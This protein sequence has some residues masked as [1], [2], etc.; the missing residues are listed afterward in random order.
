MTCETDREHSIP[1]SGNGKRE[2]LID[3]ENI[4]SAMCQVT[5]N[6]FSRITI[7][8]AQVEGNTKRQ[9]HVPCEDVVFKGITKEFLL[10]GLADGQSGTQYGAAGGQACLEAIFGLISSVGIETLIHSPFPD[11]LPCLFVQT[12]RKVL[13]PMANSK[14]TDLKEFAST[15]LIIAV[16]LKSG[17][18]IL[19]H[20]GDGYAI[21]IPNTG[22]PAL[23]SKPDTGLTSR[24]TWLTTS[25]NAIPHFYVTFG[26]IENKK[27]ILLVS[28]GAVCFC[29]GQHIPWR[30]KDL[31]TDGSQLQLHEYLM[32]SEPLD[33]ATYIVLDFHST[34]HHSLC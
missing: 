1:F 25:D 12:I 5:G 22:D 2:P 15:L 31:L 6:D 7:S 33:D 3:P 16:S 19:L 32:Q 18:Y 26:S 23:I 34:V 29:R 11:E 17:Q 4:W 14:N 21:S 9:T 24:H 10:Y 28:D 13:L 20:L 27:R 30:A 8:H